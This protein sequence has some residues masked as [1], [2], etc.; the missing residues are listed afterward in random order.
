MET[1][2]SRSF[3]LYFNFLV[4]SSCADECKPLFCL[5]LF[6]HWF[7]PVNYLSDFFFFLFYFV[8]FY[9]LKGN[10]DSLGL[11]VARGRGG[12]NWGCHAASDLHMLWI[13]RRSD[14]FHPSILLGLH[15]D[16]YASLLVVIRLR[17]STT[18]LFL[19]RCVAPKVLRS[20]SSCLSSLLNGTETTDFNGRR[21]GSS[22]GGSSEWSH[23]EQS[24]LPH[25]VWSRAIAE[26]PGGSCTAPGRTCLTLC[27][28]SYRCCNGCVS[29]CE[30]RQI[31]SRMRRLN[32]YLGSNG[33]NKM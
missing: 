2:S 20:S 32:F 1:V 26:P 24:G 10:A 31:S 4:K 21:P 14:S 11:L 6:T 18:R 19:T 30:V 33:A 15:S 22:C 25:W 9:M 17:P 3:L 13:L 16:F 23:N 27:V 7:S 8:L 5:S 12:V 28:F 29:S